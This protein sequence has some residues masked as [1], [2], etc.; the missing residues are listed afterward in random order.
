MAGHLG[1]NK[2]FLRISQY[3]YWP[4]LQ[5]SVVEYQL[6]GKPNQYIRPAP[7]HP[8]RLW[9]SRLKD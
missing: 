9:G 6:A 2:T 1:E 8:I 7:L 5:S 3:F 4:G